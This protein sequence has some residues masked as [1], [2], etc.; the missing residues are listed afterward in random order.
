MSNMQEALRRARTPIDLGSES[1]DFGIDFDAPNPST[2]K[3][4]EPKPHH[5]AL[6]VAS[7]LRQRGVY[8]TLL[9]AR[10]TR[11]IASVTELLKQSTGACACAKCAGEQNPHDG[12]TNTGHY[13]HF[14]ENCWLPCGACGGKKFFTPLDAK[15]QMAYMTRGSKGL[16][17][18]YTWSNRPTYAP[19]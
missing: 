10:A 3:V 16:A 7:W 9:K 18:E 13:W 4:I 12:S 1:L 8:G 15:R 6:E 14:K 17:N 5:S 2:I 11:L 19:F